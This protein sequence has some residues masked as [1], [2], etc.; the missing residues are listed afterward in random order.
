MN[1]DRNVTCNLVG[2]RIFNRKHNRKHKEDYTINRNRACHTIGLRAVLRP[3]AFAC[4][5]GLTLPLPTWAQQKPV[6]GETAGRGATATNNGQPA[7]VVVQQTELTDTVAVVPWSYRNGKDPAIQTAREVCNELLLETGFNVFLLQSPGGAMPPAM[8]GSSASRVPESPF[9][10]ILDQGRAVLG[11]E[12]G[13][14]ANSPYVLPT[15]D[16]MSAIGAKTGAR[17]ILAGRAQWTSHNVWVGIANRVKAFC[18]VDLRILDM[19]DK[20]LVLDAKNILGDST[21]NKSLFVTLSSAVSLNPIP[22]VLPGSVT[23]QQQRAVTVAAARAMEPWLKIERV[24]TALKQADESSEVT[25]GSSGPTPKFSTLIT[26]ISDLQAT[27]QTSTPDP[28]LA[29]VDKDLVRLSE[30]HDMKLQYK[31]PNKLRLTAESPKDGRETLIVNEVQR[32]YVIP[33]HDS[34]RTEDVSS[35]P[36]RRLSLLDCC[37]LLTTGMFDYLRAR[38]VREEQ[39]EGMNTVVYDLTYWG[40]EEGP[41]HRV[42]IDPKTHIVIRHELYNTAG[43][44]TVVTRYERPTEI[45]SHI[46]LPKHIVVEN[47]NQKILAS[48]T[49]TNARVNQGISDDQ[50]IVKTP[51][52]RA[53]PKSGIRLFK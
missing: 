8:P 45:A 42:W 33:D 28:Q 18:T 31:E 47:A 20:R 26:S 4:A 29:A 1:V 40:I 30:L 16:E 3:C 44:L 17:Y 43:K 13:N 38:F 14:K 34:V 7:P 23:P 52:H 37:G 12:T 10:H 32:S 9:A 15:V 5:L 36:E 19:A 48:I 2:I 41:F 11:Q 49:V 21:E 25:A 35:A 39:M 51:A 27:L 53:R 46:W 6:R 22:L 24:K 50:F